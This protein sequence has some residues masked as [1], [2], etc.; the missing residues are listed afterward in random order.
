M[1]TKTHYTLQSTVIVM[2]SGQSFLW[3]FLC[4]EHRAINAVPCLDH[5]S[6]LT[7]TQEYFWDRGLFWKIPAPPNQIAI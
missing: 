3:N 2:P 4:S 6:C 7:F 5:C 1:C